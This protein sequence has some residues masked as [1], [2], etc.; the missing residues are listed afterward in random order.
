MRD[1]NYQLKLLCKHSHEG[2][3]ETRV[4]RER[5]LSAIAN[6]LHDLGFRQ[7]KATSLKQK[8]VKALV[9]HW[10]EQKLSPGT[11]KNRMSCLRWWAEKVNKRAVVAGSNDFYGVP[12][13]Q[14][15]SE[16]SKAKDLAEGQLA[17]VRDEHVRMSLRL[18]QAF[19]LRREEALKIQP[20]WADRGKYLHLKASW[21]KG[22]RE[23]TVPIRN[24]EQRALLEQSKQLAGLGS[25]IP[26]GR[27]YIEQLR[28]YERH[29]ANAGLSKM[30]GLR[31]A[32]AQ[33]RYQEL[34]GW[35]SPHTGG[36][37]R[38]QMT[39]AQRQSDQEARL[40]ISAEIGHRREQ[41]TAVYLGR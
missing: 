9:E 34:T 19:G 36:P 16:Q 23:R 11:I 32:Y 8:H 41:I 35:P 37:T 2:S 12:D 28:I 13:R 18:Q 7:L 1:L 29:T 14:F 39:E 25:L 6:Q 27:Q 3:F 38:E 17:Q 15:V 4:G 10:L 26:G 33:Q 5:Q 24:T 22:G 40:T 31:H 30:H 20:R 21:T